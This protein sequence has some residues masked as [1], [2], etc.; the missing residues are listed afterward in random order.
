MTTAAQQALRRLMETVPNTRFILICNHFTKIFEPVQSRCAV[1]KFDRLCD[2][3]MKFRLKEIIVDLNLCVDDECLN[4]VVTLSEGDFR[5]VINVLQ[6]CMMMEVIDENTILK[7]VGQPSPKLIDQI[8]CN[9]VNGKEKEAVEMFEMVWNEKFDPLDIIKSFF[10]SA[11]QRDS[12]ELLKCIGPV[13]LRITEG[14][15]T[16]LQ[17]YGMFYDILNIK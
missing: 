10:R 2:D 1:L 3:E 12:Y 7:I 5:Q 15:N 13:E 8:M 17:F 16:K 6:S 14:V 11:R 4:L 9:L